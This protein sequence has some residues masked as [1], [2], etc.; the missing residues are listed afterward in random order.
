MAPAE[1]LGLPTPHIVGVGET[2]ETKSAQGVRGNI[3]GTKEGFKFV[4]DE[5]LAIGQGKEY[6]RLEG[7]QIQLANG[8]IAKPISNNY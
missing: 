5:D 2:L 6:T 4:P 8:L 3:V 7:T 1:I